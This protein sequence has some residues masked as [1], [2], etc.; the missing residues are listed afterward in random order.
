[1]STS[2]IFLNYTDQHNVDE[3]VKSI[4]LH[5]GHWVHENKAGIT[6][7]DMNDISD[8]LSNLAPYVAFM[9][10]KNSLSRY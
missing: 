2:K 10:N 8:I 7:R 3:D 9:R 5:G 4:P 6:H 1:M